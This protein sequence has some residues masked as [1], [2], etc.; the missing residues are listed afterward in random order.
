MINCFLII[1]GKTC[2]KK[3][4]SQFNRV[5]S[6]YMCNIKMFCFSRFGN[7]NKNWKV[8]I[9][10]KLNWEL[11]SSQSEP[12][13]MQA[14]VL[15]PRP[16]HPPPLLSV[17]T[18]FHFSVANDTYIFLF[19]YQEIPKER[20]C[21]AVWWYNQRSTRGH[22]SGLSTVLNGFIYPTI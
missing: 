18:F 22:H 4:E 14:Y 16:N 9:L 15:S 5:L 2:A 12:L 20:S 8:K 3:L 1:F 17:K 19:I 21:S 6:L 10:L 7:F 11:I 13:V